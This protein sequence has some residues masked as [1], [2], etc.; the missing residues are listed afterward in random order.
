MKIL[1]FIILIF[2]LDALLN[3]AAV[4][5]TETKKDEVKELKDAVEK[6]PEAILE[7]LLKKGMEREKN[8]QRDAF[9]KIIKDSSE[10]DKNN[11]IK[12]IISDEN[13]NG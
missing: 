2:S 3:C 12:L 11:L 13:K 8:Q 10:T 1:Y 4:S 6:G 9:M 7:L 5:K